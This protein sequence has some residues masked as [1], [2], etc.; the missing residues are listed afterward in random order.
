MRITNIEQLNNTFITVLS[1]EH[2]QSLQEAFFAMGGTWLSGSTYYRPFNSNTHSFLSPYNSVV[3]GNNVCLTSDPIEGKEEVFFYNGFFQ[4]VSEDEKGYTL[5]EEERYLNKILDRAF[6]EGINY[7]DVDGCEEE[8][9]VD[10]SFY[11]EAKKGT[12]GAMQNLLPEGVELVIKSDSVEVIGNNG[13]Y[14]E[15]NSEEDLMKLLK[16]FKTLQEFEV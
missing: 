15:P 13:E 10:G 6:N 12:I 14:Y 3:F 11:P 16:A 2:D 1:D 4:T 8:E 9:L 7:I 5:T